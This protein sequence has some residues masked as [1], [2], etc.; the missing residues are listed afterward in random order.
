MGALD[1]EGIQYE[2]SGGLK[3]E[4]PEV[5]PSLEEDHHDGME[6]SP[7][8]DE[9]ESDDEAEDSDN[10]EQIRAEI[11]NRIKRRKLKSIHKRSLHQGSLCVK[12]VHGF[13]DY[14][15]NQK[16]GRSY[17]I[18]PELVSPVPF[19]MGT[20]CRNEMVVHGADVNGVSRV[21]LGGVLMPS[22]VSG[23]RGGIEG[24]LGGAASPAVVAMSSEVDPRTS[25][26][27]QLGYIQ[28]GGCIE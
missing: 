5:E 9:D 17:V 16:H 23:V 21:R 28:K 10:A 8:V 1:R 12:D 2:V 4:S 15:L 11:S 13:V 3:P 25:T 7:A 18:L 27:S 19:L 22:S 14:L 6:E 26:L 20:C 24:L